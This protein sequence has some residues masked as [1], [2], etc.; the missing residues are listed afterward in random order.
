LKGTELLIAQNFSFFRCGVRYDPFGAFR[1]GDPVPEAI[2]WGWETHL[3]VRRT[4]VVSPGN[5]IGPQTKYTAG[6]PHIHYGEVALPVGMERQ[7]DIVIG[8]NSLLVHGQ[9]DLDVA[10]GM[11]VG[12]EDVNIFPVLCSRAILT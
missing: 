12:G 9:G 2:L 5:I 10:L 6:S 4:P 7:D 8:P 1:T 11:R 3:S